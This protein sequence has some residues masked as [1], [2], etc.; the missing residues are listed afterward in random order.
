MSDSDVVHQLTRQPGWKILKKKWLERKREYYEKL[1]RFSRDYHIRRVQGYLDAIDD[2][3]RDV[4]LTI[5]EVE[6]EEGEE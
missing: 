5:Q 6:E 1:R 4:D 2:M 3:F